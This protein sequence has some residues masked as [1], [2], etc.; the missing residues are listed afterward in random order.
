M[1]K[2]RK[3]TA[4]NAAVVKTQNSSNT[5]KNKR[6]SIHERRTRASKLL[7]ERKQLPVY[8]ARKSIVKTIKKYD[9]VVIVGETGSGKTTQIRKLLFI[10]L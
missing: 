9:T 1:H 3:I 8:E 7:K 5:V 2:R 6:K 4:V 10:Y